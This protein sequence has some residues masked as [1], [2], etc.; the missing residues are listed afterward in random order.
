MVGCGS[1]YF[2]THGCSLFFSGCAGVFDEVAAAAASFWRALMSKKLAMVDVVVV[3]DLACLFCSL[4]SSMQTKP[5]ARDAQHF[6]L[7][8][9]A[10]L[11]VLARKSVPR[12]SI[13]KE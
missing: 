13:A 8:Q 12:I 4:V 3:V 6:S 7:A 9:S 2:S 5:N 10:S 11:L 1:Y